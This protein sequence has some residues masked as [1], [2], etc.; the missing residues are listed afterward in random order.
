MSPEEARKK[1][2]ELSDEVDGMQQETE[3]IYDEMD[4]LEDI[5]MAEK[6]AEEDSE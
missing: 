2:D 5:F 1:Y 4:A 6:W 3:R